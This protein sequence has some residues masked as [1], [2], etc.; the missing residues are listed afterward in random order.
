MKT[1][2]NEGEIARKKLDKE[3]KIQIAEIERVAKI[4]AK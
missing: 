3:I 2:E 4:N 1:E